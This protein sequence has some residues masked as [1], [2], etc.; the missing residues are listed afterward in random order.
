MKEASE[1]TD[2]IWENRHWLP[3]D[4]FKRKC[5]VF[6][7]IF[8]ILFFSFKTIFMLQKKSLAMKGRYPKMLCDDYIDQYHDRRGAW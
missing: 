6:G 5:I 2:I 4:R 3:S 7:I 1:P 8:T